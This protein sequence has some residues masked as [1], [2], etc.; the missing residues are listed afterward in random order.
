MKKVYKFIYQGHGNILETV[1]IHGDLV[2][3]YFSDI[4]LFSAHKVP[5]HVFRKDTC[6][7]QELGWS[8]LKDY[9]ARLKELHFKEVIL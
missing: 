7:W 9:I 3:T 5:R 2:D 6:T 1:V 8:C 4:N